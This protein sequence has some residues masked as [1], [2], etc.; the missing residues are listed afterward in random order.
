MDIFTKLVCIEISFIILL[1]SWMLARIIGA[2]SHPA[3][4]Y[5]VFWFAMTMLPL[6][7]IFPAP[8]HPLAIAYI[9]ATVVAFSVPALFYSWSTSIEIAK[10]RRLEPKNVAA[11]DLLLPVFFVLQILTVAF[12][13]V[14]FSAQGY[15]IAEFLLNPIRM[16]NRY[17][18]ARYNGEIHP[19]VF[20]QTG[21]LFN[22]VAAAMGGLVIARRRSVRWLALISVFAFAPSL[23][24]MVLYGDKGTLFLVSAYFFGGVVVARVARGDLSLINKA[25]IKV[26]A[27]ALMVLIPF[28]IFTMLS[29]GG[30]DWH[31]SERVTKV[32][33]YLDS[34]AFGHL[35]A[36]SDWFSHYL[37]DATSLLYTNPRS[38]TNGFYT[39]MAIGHLIYPGYQITPGVFGEYFEIPG[40][41]KTNIYTMFR[42][43]IFDFGVTGSLV[44]IAA[45][46]LI[47]SLAYNAML[48]RAMSSLAQSFFILS[49]GC[50]YTSYIISLLIWNS[51]YAAAIGV[52]CLL[53]A[54][55]AI[56]SW[57]QLATRSIDQISPTVL[58]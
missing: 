30:G 32:V 42:P 44:F 23:L 13:F 37:F 43:L 41:I 22:Y 31:G 45:W 57:K 9:L 10:L 34:Y 12:V 53:A 48:R 50:I 14:N 15:S 25:T 19:N 56:R 35:F 3:V 6:V 28:L 20:S 21:I 58:F 40:L 55:H 16:S 52:T 27:I 26:A 54:N 24:Y 29:R 18:A 8:A 4:I 38:L 49:L 7:A 51:A 2:W 11:F 5:A 17:I 47:A 33:Y 36:F 1:Y 39:F 46:G